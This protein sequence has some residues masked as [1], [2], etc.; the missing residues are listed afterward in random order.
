MKKI[1]FSI[2]LF[3]IAYGYA[4]TPISLDINDL[5]SPIRFFNARTDT[6]PDVSITPG[7]AGANITWNFS[8]LHSTQDT[9][10]V[11]VVDPS[12]IPG[13]DLF[14]GAN[15]AMIYDSA[16]NVYFFT[17]NSSGLILHGIINDFLN[18]GDSIAVVLST[19]DTA[20]ALPANYGDIST[21]YCFGD[22]KSHCTY[23]YDTNFGGFPVSVPIDTVRIKHIQTIEDALDAWGTVTTPNNSFPALRQKDI[24]YSH[25]SIWG[26]A[27][28][29][30][31]YES[32]S[33]WYFMISRK[34]T[35]L[36]YSWWT[37]AFGMP[38]VK[39]TMESLT[40]NVVRNVEWAYDVYH[41]G[42]SENETTDHYVYPNPAGEFVFVSGLSGCKELVVYDVI[43]NEVLRQDL[44]NDMAKINV[45]SLSN[46][47]YFYNAINSGS[48]VYGKFMVKH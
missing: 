19:P 34:D 23:S 31:P 15:T 46:G 5:A 1:V 2:L 44:S 47:L 37:K 28:V 21:Y 27:A 33:G 11:D 12:V 26:Y 38:A 22:S 9:L 39:M 18:T 7:S 16:V 42:I 20:L 4:Q 17:R 40:S 24:T 36:T 30:P 45:Q 25:D 13:H 43:G 32:Y 10:Y 3:G 48:K 6:A 35:T 41:T 29:P 8:A 14:P